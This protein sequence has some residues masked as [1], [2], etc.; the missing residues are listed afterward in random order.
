M[1]NA[2]STIEVTPNASLEEIYPIISV[3]GLL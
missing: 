2:K 1:P 3:I